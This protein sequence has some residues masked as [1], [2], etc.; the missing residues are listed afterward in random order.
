MRMQSIK[1]LVNRH[2][3]AETVRVYG[4]ASEEALGVKVYVVRDAL[5]SD[6]DAALAWHLAQIAVIGAIRTAANN[7][8]RITFVD[9]RSMPVLFPGMAARP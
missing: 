3:T 7:G 5:F 6:V 2:A 8:I 1:L 9:E 4:C